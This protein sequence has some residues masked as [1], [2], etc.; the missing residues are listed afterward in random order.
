VLTLILLV[1]LLLAVLAILLTAWSLWFQGY[2]YSEPAGGLHWRGPAAAGAVLVVLLLWI[3]LDYRSPGRY[4][5]LLEFSSSEDSKQFA[6]LYIPKP[7]SKDKY[8]LY[9]LSG[10]TYKLNGN[11]AGKPLPQQPD[12]VKVIEDGQ[13]YIFEPERDAKGN[14]KARTT[15]STFGSV[16]EYQRYIDGKG[17]VMTTLGKIST[18]HGGWLFLNLL[19]N[20]LL[21]SVW[22]V[23]LWLLVRFQW[24]HALGQAFV[25]WSVMLVFVLPPLLSRVEGVAKQREEARRLAE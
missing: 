18:F 12:R 7:G 10:G 2:V 21:L 16:S 6:E 9:R 14:F 22:F 23:A 19:L 17:R 3:I 5:P 20:F 25:F 8:D 1:L 11:P 13:E 4:R 15:K 24:A